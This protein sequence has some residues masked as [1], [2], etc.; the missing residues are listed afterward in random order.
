MARFDADITRAVLRGKS[1]GSE[2]ST[3]TGQIIDYQRFLAAHVRLWWKNP[4]RGV[5]MS[6]VFDYG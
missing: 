2:E 5:L 4:S 6:G 3:V 1:D